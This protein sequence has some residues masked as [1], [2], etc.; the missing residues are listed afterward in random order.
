MTTLQ[1]TMAEQF[2]TN[3][4]AEL[5]RDTMRDLV[6]AGHSRELAEAR[7]TLYRAWLYL[8]KRN[9]AL[10]SAIHSGKVAQS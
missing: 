1:N 7:S 4:A 10:L 5:I 9:M 2:N 8:W 3:R 6:G